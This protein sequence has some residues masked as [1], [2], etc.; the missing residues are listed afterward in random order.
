VYIAYIL[1]LQF[2]GQKHVDIKF[3]EH[4]ACRD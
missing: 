3:S 2:A 4:D 1:H